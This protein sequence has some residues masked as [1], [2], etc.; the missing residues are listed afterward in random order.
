MKEF[1]VW[2]G[3]RK[4][5]HNFT[6]NYTEIINLLQN[7]ADCINTENVFFANMI[8]IVKYEYRLFIHPYFGEAFEITLGKCANTNRE[9]KEAHNVLN[10]LLA[11]EFDTA[12]CK[13]AK[14]NF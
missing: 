4:G 13:V 6:N 9:M 7:G 10:L 11:G 12:N 5:F 3:E 2:F 14:N 8:I 1:H